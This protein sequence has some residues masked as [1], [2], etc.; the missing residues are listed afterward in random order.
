VRAAGAAAWDAAGAAAGA[1]ARDAAWDAAGAAA[2]AAAW[3]AAGEVLN[4]TVIILQ[5]SALALY[6][7][8]IRGT[9]DDTPKGHACCEHCRHVKTP[10]GVIDPH[11][12][13]PAP[14]DA[15]C[16]EGCNDDEG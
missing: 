12:S 5:E 15:P 1:A 2:R 3:D 9:W 4:P 11:A 6:D 10:G 16:A 13:D 8:M 14:H 7:Q